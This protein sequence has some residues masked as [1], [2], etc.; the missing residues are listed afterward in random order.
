M[1]KISKKLAAVK[2]RYEEYQRKM[3]ELKKELKESQAKAREAKLRVKEEKLKLKQ[4]KKR[5]EK[6]VYN[7]LVRQGVDGA[8]IKDLLKKLPRNLRGPA[9]QEI[10]QGRL[11]RA[12][13]VYDDVAYEAWQI[14]ADLDW[15]ISEVFDA[16]DYEENQA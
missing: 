5:V 15:D 6:I 8:P 4:E 11:D 7:N 2:L 1:K 13:H 16:W 3:A 9:T 14:A 10:I 12:A